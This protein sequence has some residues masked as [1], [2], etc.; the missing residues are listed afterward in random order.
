MKRIYFGQIT[1]DTVDEF[2]DVVLQLAEKAMHYEK[3]RSQHFSGGGV[4]FQ[5]YDRGFTEPLTIS[6]YVNGDDTATDVT[7]LITPGIHLAVAPISSSK[8]SP[9][10]DMTLPQAKAQLAEYTREG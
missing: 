7:V 1:I 8:A 3:Q 9:V 4:G 6:G 5:P 10:V 2:A